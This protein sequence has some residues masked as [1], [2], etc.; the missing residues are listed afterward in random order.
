MFVDGER[1]TRHVVHVLDEKYTTMKPSV[2]SGVPAPE[3]STSGP[4]AAG[5][6]API[7]QRIALLDVL[8]GISVLGILLLN[9]AAFSG[10]AFLDPKT[11]A[12]LPGASG[13]RTLHFLVV[14]LVE[15]KFYSLFSLLFGIGFAVMV[16][17]AERA[18]ANPVPVLLRRYAALLVLGSV[19]AFLIW[20]G[21]I[22]ILYALLGFVLLLFLRQPARVLVTWAVV[23]LAVPIVLYGV[24]LTVLPADWGSAWWVPSRLVTAIG[25]FKSGSYGQVVASNV[26]LAGMM[27]FRRLVLLFYPRVFGMFV[28][29]FALGRL[30]VF[31]APGRH[32]ALFRAL[33]WG[34]LLVGLPG[35]IV[36]ALVE[37]AEG[38]L[39]LTSG[40]Y[41][42]TVVDSIATPLLSL[43]YV[44]WITWLFQH[45]RGQRALGWLA[46]VGRM[47]L[48]NYLL[49]SIVLTWTFYG[50]GLGWF[51][52][53]S[54]ATST[55]IALILYALQIVGSRLWLSRFGYGP[56]EWVWR[57]LTY[58]KRSQL[59]RR[60]AD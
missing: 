40:D 18:G 49:H 45:A 27:W 38:F 44:A 29:G 12:G 2:V 55:A 56:V 51:M 23:L 33:S 57:W 37:R 30:R 32:A 13:D 9:I 3:L 34:G 8:R 59:L 6:L 60:A 25:A 1:D 4:P 54:V 58:G 15:G 19:H 46:P 14:W 7:A 16:T 21:D 50:M 22:L 36:Y 35:S 42:R 53:T 10:T 43:G 47:A 26:D 39:P 20:L 48:T 24:G 11:A 17:R 41:V 5:G 52:R 31:E 28:L